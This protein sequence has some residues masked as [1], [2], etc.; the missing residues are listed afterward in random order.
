MS[1][2]LERFLWW[3]S[4]RAGDAAWRLEHR[5]RDYALTGPF[6]MAELTA[7]QK[8]YNAALAQILE[9]GTKERS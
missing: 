2:R 5:R 6:Y 1:T 9:Y 8:V 3:I 7:A 4:D